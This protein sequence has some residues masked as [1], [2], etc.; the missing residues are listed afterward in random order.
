MTK[1]DRERA[2]G[3]E[4]GKK[5]E[6]CGMLSFALIDLLSENRL[7]LLTAKKHHLQFIHL[8]PSPAIIHQAH[9]LY[10]ITGISITIM[11]DKAGPSLRYT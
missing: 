10:Y 4:H 1:H 3:R 5:G 6:S 11:Q 7:A 8:S 9:C 2:K